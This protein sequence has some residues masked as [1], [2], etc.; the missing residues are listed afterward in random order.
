ME[1]TQKGKERRTFRKRENI[2][3]KWRET[4]TVRG[5]ERERGGLRISLTEPGWRA[6]RKG[7][8]FGF[9]SF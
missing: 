9:L 8:W 4:E 7:I 1:V 3:R 5:G 2:G 6:L